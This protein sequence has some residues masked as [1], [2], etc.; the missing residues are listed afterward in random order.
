MKYAIVS[1]GG[2]QYKAIEGMEILVDKLPQKAG[3]KVKFP[4]ILLYRNEEELM[5]GTPTVENGNVIG[6]VIDQVKGPKVVTSKFKAKVNYRRK[7]GFRAR[8]TR[9]L[10]ET[11]SASEVL[12]RPAGKKKRPGKTR[13]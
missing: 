9:I 4:T 8:Q 5:I 12:S 6:K 13:V 11:V 1:S 7:I 10:I 2:K 3:E